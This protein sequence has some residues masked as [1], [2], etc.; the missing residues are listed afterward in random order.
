MTLNFLKVLQGTLNELFLT[1]YAAANVTL[2]VQKYYG[3]SRK[4]Y[5]FQSL[6]LQPNY[7]LPP[8]VQSRV[9]VPPTILL[10]QLDKK[11]FLLQPYFEPR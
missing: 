4:S 5:N 11:T 9:D 2:H 8:T 3:R 10:Q 7:A 6:H 1:F